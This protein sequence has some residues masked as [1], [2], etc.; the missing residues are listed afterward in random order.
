MAKRIGING[1]GRIGRLVF[2]HMMNLGQE[3]VAVN[4]IDEFV[5]PRRHASWAD[6]LNETAQ[7]QHAGFSFRSAFFPAQ[8]GHGEHFL[9]TLNNDHRT[10]QVNR[11]RNKV[12][13]YPLRVFEIG[14]H[15]IS[16]PILA[17]LQVPAIA[18]TQV[19]LHHYRGCSSSYLQDCR[20]YTKDDRVQQLF[21]PQLEQ[22]TLR[23]L[24]DLHIDL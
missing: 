20:V 8:Q 13:T 12:M 3:V 23:A 6:W 22:V 5:V 14:I 7:V 11:I 9:V 16:K 15:H 1:F 2:R 24:K 18:E 19:L 17:K 21:G 4:D 10:E